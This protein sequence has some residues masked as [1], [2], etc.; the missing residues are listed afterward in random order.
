MVGNQATVAGINNMLTQLY[1]QYRDL[2]QQIGNEAEDI[3]K[4]GS[5]GLQALGFSSGDATAILADVSYMN[6]GPQIFCGTATQATLF[7][8]NDALAHLSAGG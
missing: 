1:I 7:N 5:A 3:N 2:C 4:L 6:T 8:F